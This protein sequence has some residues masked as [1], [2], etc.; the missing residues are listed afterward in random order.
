MDLWWFYDGIRYS[1]L[2]T[3]E[4]YFDKE[5]SNEENSNDSDKKC[6]K[7]EKKTEEAI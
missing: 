5:D 6:S 1:V 4:T 3:I 2:F 7:E